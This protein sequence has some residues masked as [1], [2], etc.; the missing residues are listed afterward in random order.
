MNIEEHLEPYEAPRVVDLGRLADLTG[1]TDTG[2]KSE[3]GNVK[4]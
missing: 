3:G 2:V 1:G 4:T